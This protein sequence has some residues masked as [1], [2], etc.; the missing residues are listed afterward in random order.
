MNAGLP[1]MGTYLT[2]VMLNDTGSDV[3]TLFHYE[4]LALGY[5]PLHDNRALRRHQDLYS[6]VLLMSKCGSWIIK[7]IPSQIGFVNELF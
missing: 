1:G 6:E 7:I 3:S 2:T 5:N 4:A